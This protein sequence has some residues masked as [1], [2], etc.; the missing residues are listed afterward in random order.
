MCK[1]KKI[2]KKNLVLIILSA[3]SVH[4]NAQSWF[5]LMQQEGKTFYEVQAAANDFYKDKQDIPSIGYKQFKRWENYM[6]PRVYPSGDMSLP[7]KN[8]ESFLEFINQN[9]ALG[10][11]NSTSSSTT[12]TAMGPMGPLAGVATNGF[13][14]KAGRD[15]FITFHPTIPTTFWAGA[16]AGGLWKTTDGGVTWTTNT[17]YLTVTGCSDLAVD[18]SNTNILY[19]ATGDGDAGDTYCIGVL[20][21]TD[22][23]VTW[24]ST[25]LTFGVNQTRQMRRLVINPSNPQILLA[26]TNSGLYRTTD[27]GATWN[28]ALTGNWYDIEFKPGDPNTV[29]VGGNTTFRRSTDGGATFS[30]ISSGFP[31]S[32]S[33]RLA[34]A[35]TPADPSYVYI[36]RSNSSSN[37]G[38]LYRS[39]NDGTSF[40]LMSNSPDVIANSCAGTASGN[41][42][43]WYDL[44]IAVS[45][46]DKDRVDV[47]GVNVWSSDGGGA[48]GTWTCTGCWIGT[49]FPSVYM[50]ADQHDLEYSS[51]GSLYA[52][53]DGGIFRY[54][55]T[56]WVDLNNQRNIAQIYKIGSSGI[57]ANKWVSGHQD[58]GTGIYNNGTYQASYAG[59]GMDCF[60]DRTN[61]NNIFVSTPNG[62]FRRSTD[63]GA[64]YNG[65]TNGMTGTGAWVSPWK[66]DPTLAS[67]L[68]AGRSQLFV[69]NNLGANWSQAGTTGASGSITEF[70]IAPS[71]NQVIYLIQATSIR[72]TTNGASTWS[73]CANVG[74]IPTF[75]TIDPTNENRL[76]VTVSGYSGGNKVFQSVNG[77]VS[78]TNISYN[79]PNLPA[80][81][82]VY[83]PGSNDRLYIGMDV[84]VYT[85][86]AS[87]NTWTLYNTGLPNT[88]VSDFEISPAAPGLLRVA[89]YGRGVY[90][91]DLIQA[92]TVPTSNFA[93][94]ATICA[95]VASNFTDSSTES[96][97]GWNWSVNPPNGVTI[98]SSTD[99][100]PAITFANSGTY[101]VSMTANN[102]FGTG[103]TATQTV[104]VNA[105]PSI[106]LSSSGTSQNYCVDEEIVLTASGA[107]TYTWL[108]GPKTS[109][110]I[111]LTISL[112]TPSIYTVNAKSIEGCYNTELISLNISECTGISNSKVDVGQFE[113]YPNPANQ[114]VKIRTK[115]ISDNKVEIELTDVSGKVIRKTTHQ[116]KKDSKEM[117]FDISELVRGVYFLDLKISSGNNQKYKFVKE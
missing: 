87:S 117:E 19:L 39:T 106:I 46:N 49:T 29:Y 76:W 88:P 17:D 80:N 47:G 36:L 78:W 85:K 90:Q 43:G 4:F 25:G 5:E 1:N 53:S 110:A 26:A 59:D 22:G 77:G 112:A 21:S 81:C 52:A 40:T 9:Q 96:P 7:S 14:R 97:T 41:G 31:T 89:T 57:S 108:P 74:G 99:Q 15:N 54:N 33:N 55:S 8:L 60:I 63:G 61:D 44:A 37:F 115:E 71:N 20:K 102:G 109:A 72:K 45:P 32:G 66:Q 93:P 116:F 69:S 113:I 42:Q 100:N 35:V 104:I 11:S 82:S 24:N 73:G 18:P 51:T 64:T 6:E 2:M 67:R 79:L 56:S 28:T 62:N 98:N 94:S 30:T 27:G 12:Y 70:A 23:G 83:Q 95:G 3:F 91:V 75:I 107:N 34:I 86:D 105:L 10:K 65:A 92:T 84:G 101:V 68:Y 114:F 13:P 48:T 50:K 103:S 16:P 58:N 111:N 38:G